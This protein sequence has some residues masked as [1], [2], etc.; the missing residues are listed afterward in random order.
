M[1]TLTAQAVQEPPLDGVHPNDVKKPK[2]KKDK[3]AA[4]ATSQYP[5]EVSITGIGG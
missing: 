3:A 4:A 2:D 1:A 5:L